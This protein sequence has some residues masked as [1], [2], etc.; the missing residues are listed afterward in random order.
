MAGILQFATR[1][2]LETG[3]MEMAFVE[4]ALEFAQ[5][6]REGLLHIR[7]LDHSS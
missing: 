3:T 2:G 7:C 6:A 5:S 1:R 4:H